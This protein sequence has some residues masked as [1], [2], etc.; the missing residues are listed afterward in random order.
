MATDRSPWVTLRLPVTAG[1]AVLVSLTLAAALYYPTT[2][3]GV[4]HDRKSDFITIDYSGPSGGGPFR[5]GRPSGE[6]A[7]SG[8]PGAQDLALDRGPVLVR[9]AAISRPAQERDQPDH[10]IP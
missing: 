1:A 6:E 4:S 9:V 7:L 8:D 5:G 10:G 3:T 2:R